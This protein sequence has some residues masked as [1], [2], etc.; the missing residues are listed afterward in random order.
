MQS[1]MSVTI[2]RPIKAVFAFA[3]TKVAEWST[4]VVED[5]VVEELNGGGVGTTFHVVTEERGKRMDFDSVLTLH[6]PPTRCCSVMPGQYFDIETDMRFEELDG[7]TRVSQIASVKGK[8]STRVMFA[9]FG[10]LMNKS[11]CNSMENEME[12]M[13]RIMEAS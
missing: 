12:N 8:G 6:E 4:I 7:G 13:K 10:W 5:E 1:E 9:T 3:T 11:S 2:H